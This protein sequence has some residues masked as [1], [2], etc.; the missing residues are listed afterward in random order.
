[1]TD[2]RIEYLANGVGATQ[3]HTIPVPDV[4]TALVV[5]QMNHPTGE[6]ELWQGDRQL[7]RLERQQGDLSPLWIVNAAK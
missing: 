6:V 7:A 4:A 3:R 1:M 2:L 5:A